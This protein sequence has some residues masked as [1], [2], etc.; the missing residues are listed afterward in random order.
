[1][2]N[3][4]SRDIMFDAPIDT[5]DVSQPVPNIHS[6]PSY[7]SI[8]AMSVQLRINGLQ[9]QQPSKKPNLR[10]L[11]HSI[12]VPESPNTLDLACEALEPSGRP[13][14]VALTTTAEE[15]WC[16]RHHN[17]WLELNARWSKLQKEA[18][19]VAVISSETAKQKAIKLRL[20]VDLRRQIRDRFYP[21]GGDVQD[22]IRWI[23]KLE[24]DARQLADSL[25]STNHST[26]YF[27]S[28]LT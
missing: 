1:M 11:L 17:E 16:H 23:A 10:H 8:L 28:Y 27:G 6:S 14:R 3:G 20:S 9:G 2:P 15:P 26:V 4:P 19:K 7:I 12:E 22:Y 24:A 21:R 5:D 25:L 13:C 18:E